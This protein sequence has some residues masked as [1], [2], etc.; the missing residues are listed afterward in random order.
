MIHI[1]ET[2]PLIQA[3]DSTL[4]LVYHEA[5][6]R[7]LAYLFIVLGLML[8][9]S[10]NSWAGIKLVLDE[11][12]AK[13][14][15][16][17]D[18]NTNQVLYEKNADSQIEP[19]SMTKIM[20][21]VIAFDL[22]KKGKLSLKDK[23]LV[24]ENAWRLSSA[25]YSS[26]F[27]IVGDRVSV[28][29]LLRGIIVSSGNDACVVLA[30]G[31]AG[32]EQKFVKMMNAKAKEIGL[33]NTNFTNSTGIGGQKNYSTVRDIAT[34]SS[35]MIKNYPD[36]YKY[37]S[38]KQFTWNRTGGD[39]ITQGN[40][41]PLLYTNM[42]GIDGIKTGYLKKE[43]YQLA[44]SMKFNIYER[45]IVVGSGFET[46]NLRS[47]ESAKLLAWFGDLCKNK[48][49]FESCLLSLEKKNRDKLVERNN[50]KTQIVKKEKKKI[51]IIY[52]YYYDGS[53]KSGPSNLYSGYNV[54]CIN[55]HELEKY[56]RDTKSFSTTALKGMNLL[57]FKIM[58]GGSISNMKF[59][60]EHN[61][62]YNGKGCYVDFTR[63]GIL[64]GISTTQYMHGWISSFV[65][66]SSS[67]Y[68]LAINIG[69]L[70]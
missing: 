7:L 17:I 16:L 28:E 67:N 38:E 4:I 42:I 3:P 66:S 63:S 43:K 33:Q 46:K 59:R 58:S 15:I 6:K 60:I 53:C 22:I 49:D 21:T 8:T 40:R 20:T 18:A 14:A 5:V 35:Y 47:K 50:I 70:R 54:K 13:N 29:N 56:C 12:K 61:S 52:T 37:Y 68:L 25:G 31:I 32:T 55:E 24:S 30:E 11:V 57:P 64:D 36:L 48:D 62:F 34:L 45:L 65:Y 51:K 9:I 44:A 19:A 69:A 26:M 1:K 39:P 2:F 41:N 23:L 27:M 10:V